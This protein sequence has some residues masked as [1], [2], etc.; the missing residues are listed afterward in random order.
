[1]AGGGERDPQGNVPG[2]S[3]E[4]Q[5][6]QK[7]K[8]KWGCSRWS[9]GTRKQLRWGL[10]WNKVALFHPKGANV[11]SSRHGGEETHPLCC[12]PPPTLL[13]PRIPSF[14]KRFETLANLWGIP[15][16]SPKVETKRS[17]LGCQM[18]A[19]HVQKKARGDLPRVGGKGPSEG[20]K[21]ATRTQS[22]VNVQRSRESP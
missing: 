4:N 18:W 9:R 22:L 21:A 12:L 17:P 15:V 1:M 6:A 3:K 13:K 8:D 14:P 11:A 7:Q 10:R 2:E 19:F 20:G 16:Q 5:M